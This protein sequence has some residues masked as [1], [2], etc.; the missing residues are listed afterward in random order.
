[1][2]TFSRALLLASAVSAMA[3]TG[4]GGDDSNSDGKA[5]LSLGMTDAPVDGAAEVWV[6]FSGVTLIRADG[7]A[8]TTFTFDEPKRINL[9]AYQHGEIYPLLENEEIDA[10]EYSQIRLLVDTE[11]DL[12]TVIVL[13]GG[14]TF[15]LTIPSGA[16]TGL[17]L[18]SGFTATAGG[19][20]NFTLDF[21]LR[22]SVT[23]TG[24]GEFKLRPTIRIIDNLE[25]GHI[26]GMVASDAC[27]AESEM[28]IYVYEGTVTEPEDL[29]A[30]AE[31]LV[32]TYVKTDLSYQ[33]SFLAAGEY[34]L[35]LTCIAD[36][37]DPEVDDDAF[38]SGAGFVAVSGSLT[39]TADQT[40]E[41]N[42]AVG[43]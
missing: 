6:Q 27:P 11:G 12:D 22:K 28:A 32:T 7:E 23:L 31:P 10:G 40:T 24:N 21:D 34:T 15:E 25:A 39:V 9:L 42:P 29:G 43:G 35:A 36:E 41:W 18:V 20:V 2:V 33:A 38:G 30:D 37:D 14:A 17:K 5:K 19:E 26:A 13:D 3:L 4:C 1:M 16:Q 8:E